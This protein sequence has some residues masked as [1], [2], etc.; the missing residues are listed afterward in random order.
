MLDYLLGNDKFL[1]NKYSHFYYYEI[2]TIKM[3]IFFVTENVFHFYT[4][5]HIR[6]NFTYLF[7]SRCSFFQQ[8]VKSNIFRL[9]KIYF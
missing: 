2:P 8:Y 9:L 4:K 5:C 6:D 3:N 1:R 7:D